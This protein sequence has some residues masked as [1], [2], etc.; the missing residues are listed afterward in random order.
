M[1]TSRRRVVIQ[2]KNIPPAAHWSRNDAVARSITA[3]GGG[4]S[5]S[6]LND[7]QVPARVVQSLRALGGGDDDVLDAG[8]PF[9]ADVEAGLDREGISFDQCGRVARHQI[10][11]LV[12]LDTDPMAQTM[13]EI[14]AETGVGKNRSGCSIDRFGRD[15]HLGGLDPGLLS[16][17]QLLVGLRR[18]PLEA[19]R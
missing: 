4:W 8:S 12:R 1:L 11:V 3:R 7:R 15:T 14:L 13:E 18:T 2:Q 10:R 19:S 16:L 9:A 17:P 5:R 6:R